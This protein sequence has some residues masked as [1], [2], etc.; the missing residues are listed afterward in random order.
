MGASWFI[1]DR[2]QS[3]ENQCINRAQR[4]ASSTTITQ[5]VIDDEEVVGDATHDSAIHDEH[6]KT[7][8]P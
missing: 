3:F 5:I 1:R 7:P 8:T 2:Q 6:I 4:D